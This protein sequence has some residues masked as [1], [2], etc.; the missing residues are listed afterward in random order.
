MTDD[1]RPV[2]IG[3]TT[4]CARCG[5]EHLNLVAHR[6]DRPFAPPEAAP[7]VWTHWTSC[8]TKGQPI[9]VFFT[10]PPTEGPDGPAVKWVAPT[11]DQ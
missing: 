8:P 6:L 11:G 4:N 7:L 1:L 5:G 10:T 3:K 2:V 9:M